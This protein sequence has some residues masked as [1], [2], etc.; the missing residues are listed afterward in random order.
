M[1]VANVGRLERVELR[2]F[3]PSG[4]SDFTR[5]LARDENLAIL[6][7]TLG[8]DLKLETQQRPVGSFRAE[9]LCK[10]I[11]TDRWVLIENQSEWTDHGDLGKLLTY[12]AGLEEATFIWIAAHFTDE[13]RSTLDWLNRITDERFRFFG[14]EIELWRIGT[15]PVAPKLDIVSKPD[16]RSPSAAPP[17]AVLGDPKPSESRIAQRPE[18]WSPSATPAVS[19]IDD[20]EPFE[21]WI[22]QVPDNRSS[23]AARAMSGID[24]PEPSEPWIVQ[25]PDDRSSFAARAVSAIEDRKP[26]EPRIA[27]RPEEW[28]PSATPAVSG[29]EDP[30]PSEPWIV[31]VPDDRSSS[32]T[33]AAS[34]IEDPESSESQM[35]QRPDDRSSSAGRAMSAIDDPEPFESWIVRDP[36][37]RS[38]SATRTVSAF[39]QA[40]LSEIRNMQRAYWTAFDKVL[41]ESDG[42]VGGGKKAQPQSWMA[43]SIGRSHF[44]LIAAMSRL[45]RQVRAELYISGEK[46]K[47][48]FH[49]LKAQKEE[50]E[51][52][53]GYSLDWEEL[54]AEK[55]SCISISL[56]DADP[57]NEA[58]WPR[59]HRWLAQRL[60]AMHRALSSRVAVMDKPATSGKEWEAAAKVAK[61]RGLSSR[62]FGVFWKLKD[63]EALRDAGISAMEIAQ[64]AE[65]L[66]TR[67]PNAQFDADEQHR[68]R[69][70]LGS[71]LLRLDKKERVRIVDAVFAILFDDGTNA[72]VEAQAGFRDHQVNE[73]P[74]VPLVQH[75]AS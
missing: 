17:A 70:S 34:A 39:D 48:Y 75:W 35:V 63:D 23:S 21:P 73:V 72:S 19:A 20:G 15:S 18:E 2:D 65:G 4:A 56:R 28:S 52:D 68:M 44:L 45:K 30:E 7:E 13:H 16:D 24:D 26:P 8:I 31:Q 57:K 14:V 38:S 51:R 11:G 29:I 33:R 42:L 40:Q 43:Y 59:Q 49:L 25:V 9:F 74:P 32:A 47:A 53:F 60:N 36:E 69:A 22:V 62:A 55:N 41:R 54:P 5:W 50:I 37:D 67:F 12:A 66:L 64:E 3:W 61:D 71:P 27:Q 1:S 10:D 58:D 6:G 46:A